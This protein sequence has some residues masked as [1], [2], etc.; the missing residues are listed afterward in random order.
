MRAFL[1]DRADAEINAIAAR[2]ADKSAACSDL[3]KC[4]V[5]AALAA[6]MAKPVAHFHNPDQ[7]SVVV[8]EVGE[9]LANRIGLDVAFVLAGF[10]G[11][12]ALAGFPR[13]DLLCR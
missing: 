13:G 3:V 1:K 7:A 8:W 10:R 9:K 6:D 5:N 12:L 11:A 2:C 4:G